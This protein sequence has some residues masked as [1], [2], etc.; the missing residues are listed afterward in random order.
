MIHEILKQI[1]P[2]ERGINPDIVHVP[3]QRFNEPFSK[4]DTKA[5]NP[6][7]ANRTDRAGCNREILKVNNRG[8]EIAVVNY[9]EY[10]SQF[11]G[12]TPRCDLILADSGKNR[13]KIVFCELCC[14]EERYIEPNTGNSYPEGKRARARQQMDKSI[15]ELIRMSTTAVNLLTYSEKVCL[16]AWRNYNVADLSLEAKRGNARANVQPFIRTVSNMAQ[17]ATAH[18]KKLNH[19]FFFVQINYPTAYNW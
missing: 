8:E 16:F 9:E 15:D 14:C 10:S 19:D 7:Q 18:R 3:I 1:F 6:C 4:S 2:L 17:T 12:Q 5:C 13:R 11:G